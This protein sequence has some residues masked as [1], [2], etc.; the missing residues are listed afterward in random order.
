[1]AVTEVDITEDEAP[2]LFRK[3]SLVCGIPFRFVLFQIMK[4]TGT[5]QI[6]RKEYFSMF[7]YILLY[8]PDFF[9]MKNPM[10]NLTEV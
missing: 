9:G 6:S 2:P 8:S 1:M 10:G 5:N 4:M 3:I 7:F